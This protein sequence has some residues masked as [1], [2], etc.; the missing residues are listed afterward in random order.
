MKRT[1]GCPQNKFLG[2][3]AEIYVVMSVSTPCDISVVIIMLSFSLP[4]P[5]VASS[6]LPVICLLMVS[7]RPSPHPTHVPR[8]GHRLLLTLIYIQNMVL[9]LIHCL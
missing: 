5:P 1:L 2:G 8:Q 3:L 7:F 9:T 4:H 6:P